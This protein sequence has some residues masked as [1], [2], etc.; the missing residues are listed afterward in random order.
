[1]NQSHWREVLLSPGNDDQVWELF[2]ENSK[3]GRFSTSATDQGVRD[4]IARLHE[5]LPYEGYPMVELPRSLEPLHLSLD[6]A[7]T[8]RVSVRDLTACPL[9]LRQVTTLLHCAYGASRDRKDVA[10]PRSL[11]VVPSGG[12]LYQ[13][14]IFFHTAHVEGLN[15]GLYHYN[16]AKH[17]LRLLCEGDRTQAIS[18]AMIQSEIALGAALVIFITAV[19]ER[20]VFKYG[21]RGYRF[22]LLEAGHVAQNINLVA[23]AL[24]LGAVNL[25]GYYDR[26]ID[27]FLGLDGVTHSTIY[28]AAIGKKNG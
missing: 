9:T 22:V 21:D 1:M 17:H 2:H 3:N 16:P 12:A 7:I 11:R 6:R 15:A 19:F 18:Q 28:M 8:T 24:G 26:E 23:N 14:E 10:F 20:S 25:G 13:L 27:D 4:H 5:S